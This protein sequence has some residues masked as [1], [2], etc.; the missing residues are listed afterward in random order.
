MCVCLSAGLPVSVCVCSC[1][2]LPLHKG[3]ALQQPGLMKYTI[4]LQRRLQK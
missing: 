1:F 2:S 3:E 4:T